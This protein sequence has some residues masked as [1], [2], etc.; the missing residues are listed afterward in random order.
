MFSDL[1]GRTIG[2]SLRTWSRGIALNGIMC[3]EKWDSW[4]SRSST[5][6]HGPVRWKKQAGEPCQGYSTL[7]RNPDS[8]WTW[9]FVDVLAWNA[10]VR[11][12]HRRSCLSSGVACICRIWGCW[13]LLICLFA[14]RLVGSLHPW[15]F[16]YLLIHLL[17]CCWAN[18]WVVLKKLWWF[19]W[20]ILPARFQFPGSSLPSSS[21]CTASNILQYSL[22]FP[23]P[24]RLCLR[25][26]LCLS[27]VWPYEWSLPFFQAV[28]N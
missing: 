15:Y 8:P 5:W 27:G 17:T 13:M 22:I 16:F 21:S 9:K 26:R 3:Y 25:L 14:V 20:T 4:K 12:M 7:R 2:D 18:S 1:Y 28:C 23:W 6:N 19:S 11:F 24:V 10:F